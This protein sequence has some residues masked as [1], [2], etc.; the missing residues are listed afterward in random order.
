M[1]SSFRILLASLAVIGVFTLILSTATVEAQ[2]GYGGRTGGYR[3][4]YG[5]YGGYGGYRG[6]YGG[7][8]GGY[9]GYRGGY[10]GYGGYGRRYNTFGVFAVDNSDQMEQPGHATESQTIEHPYINK[11]D[12]TNDDD[13]GTDAVHDEV[14]DNSNVFGDSED[15]GRQPSDDNSP[16]EPPQPPETCQPRQYFCQVST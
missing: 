12:V 10:G 15:S 3:R 7:Y 2:Y 16:Q 8:R 4:G 6:G 13:L 14:T 9:G 11:V 5:G 1:K